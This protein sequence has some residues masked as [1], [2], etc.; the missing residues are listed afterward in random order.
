MSGPRILAIDTASEQVSVAVGD[1]SRIEASFHVSSERRHVEALVPAIKGLLD[2]L[3]TNVHD[4]SAV[5][6]DVG[7]GLFTG[8]RVGLATARMLAGLA[9]IPVVG[10][11]S[12]TIVAHGALAAVPADVDAVDLV[13]P[14]LDARR[15]QVYWSMFRNNFSDVA[16]FEEVRP[17]RVG[18]VP[19][20]VEDLMD[21]G[22][23]AL[24]V[25]T[26]ARRYAE[27]LRACPDTVQVGD[28]SNLARAVLDPHVPNAAVLVSLAADRLESGTA[29]DA[30]PM[31]L[32][33]PDA[34]INWM[35]R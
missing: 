13:V 3:G 27:E 15:G 2:N 17:P 9:E 10:V 28:N 7:P 14:V 34:E 5:A 20:L 19:E 31:Y 6:V 33:A 29:G 35:T 25:G 23:R 21:R 11:D 16:P 8:M 12:L 18:D 32:R 26:G 4:L 30:E 22:Q 24:V 1:S